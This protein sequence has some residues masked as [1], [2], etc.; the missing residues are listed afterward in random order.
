MR[1]LGAFG[2]LAARVRGISRKLWW[3]KMCLGRDGELVC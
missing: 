1:A 3:G 2:V